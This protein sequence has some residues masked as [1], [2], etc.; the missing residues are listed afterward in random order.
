MITVKNI[1]NSSL[2]S[3]N[4]IGINKI[5]QDGKMRSVGDVNFKDCSEIASYISPVPG[6]VGPIDYFN[7]N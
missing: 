7:V 4:D 3:I 5:N 1:S 2:S 6:G